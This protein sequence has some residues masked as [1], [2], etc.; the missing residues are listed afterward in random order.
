MAQSPGPDRAR[1]LIFDVIK[2]AESTKNLIV[3]VCFAVDCGSTPAKN[4][5]F[6]TTRGSPR[7]QFTL[8]NP[9]STVRQG[10][11][12]DRRKRLPL[13]AGEHAAEPG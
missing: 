12:A 8:I 4:M 10:M 1:T 3:S 2:S 13:G 11:P 5:L 9:G 7:Q 6:A